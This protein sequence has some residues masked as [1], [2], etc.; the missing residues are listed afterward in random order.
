MTQCEERVSKN[1]GKAEILVKSAI[2]ESI[3]ELV[4][5]EGDFRT[6]SRH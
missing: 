3:S 2:I 4:K 6:S 1:D 5:V